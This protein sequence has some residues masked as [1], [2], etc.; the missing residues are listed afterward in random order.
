MDTDNHRWGVGDR[1]AS[2]PSPF[3][4][5]QSAQA[6]ILALVLPPSALVGRAVLSAPPRSHGV[7][8]ADGGVR[9]PR[10][11]LV[12]AS[13]RAG[14]MA[15]VASRCHHTTFPKELFSALLA[16]L[17]GLIPSTHA[18][19]TP[20]K[21]DEVRIYKKVGERELKLH[22]AKPADWKATDRRPALLF[23]F[24]GGW[25]GGT[26]EQFRGQSEYLATRGLVGLRV[27]YR[28]IPKGD[29]GPP[30]VCCADAKSALRWVRAHAAELGVDP[31]RIGAAGGSA[32]GHLAAFTGLVPGLDDPQDDLK[33]SAR[34]DALV[35]FNPVF[36]NGPLGGWGTARVGDRVKDFSPAHNIT[37][38]APP[39]IIFLGRE[40]R[41]IPVAT[42]ERFQANMK[43]VGVR[44]D[45]HFYA[46][47]AHGFFNQEPYKSRTLLEA[48]QFLASL[49]WLQGPPTLKP[50]DAAS[51]PTGKRKAKGSN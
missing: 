21:A 24:G 27:E 45:A 15:D 12:V 2:T 44:C 9:T 50:A 29:A 18:A 28:V 43:A 34:P 22:L 25:V 36:D 17:C 46:G 3:L 8:V 1:R 23:F 14:A 37:A 16:L 40:D 38:A 26:P 5:T 7:R 51:P 49:G 30:I 47:Q 42:V 13:Q 20:T 10:P 19:E 11:T 31:Q 41:L 4:G 48:D 33:I 6:S 39:A 35:L 32:G